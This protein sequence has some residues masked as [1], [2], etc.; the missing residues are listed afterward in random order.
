MPA[1]K[2]VQTDSDYHK[3]TA[4]RRMVQGTMGEATGRIAKNRRAKKK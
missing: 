3:Q 2:Q 1:L 4:D